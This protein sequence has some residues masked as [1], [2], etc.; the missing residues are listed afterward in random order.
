MPCVSLGDLGDGLRHDHVRRRRSERH[1]EVDQDGIRARAHL[2]DRDQETIAEALAEHA[3]CDV[4]LP[5]VLRRLLAA[6]FVAGFLAVG[7]RALRAAFFVAM[8]FSNLGQS[9]LVCMAA[10]RWPVSAA[11]K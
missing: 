8:A 9:S 3:N 1:A 6:A 7:L 4:G 2:R 5:R 10:S 11:P